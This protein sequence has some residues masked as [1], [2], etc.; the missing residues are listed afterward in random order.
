MLVLGDFIIDRKDDALWQAFT[1]QGLSVPESLDA[2]PRGIFS[3]PDPPA[4]DRF[5]DQIAWFTSGNRRRLNMEF[6]SAGSFDFVPLVSRELGL[7]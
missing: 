5:Y 6:H 7:S 3:Y 1:S 4:T 2:V